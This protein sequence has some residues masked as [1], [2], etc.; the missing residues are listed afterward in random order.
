MAVRRRPVASASD[1]APATSTTKSSV[2]RSGVSRGWGSPS[3][4]GSSEA[5]RETVRSDYLKVSK[6]KK[7]I[8][9]VDD[10]PVVKFKR[11][12][13]GGRYQ[14]CPAS[15]GVL[16]DGLTCPLCDSEVA[17]SPAY[18][19][20]VLDISEGSNNDGSWPVKTY[21]F[22]KEVHD[23][24][25][26]FL[27]P[28]SDDEPSRYDPINQEKWYWHIF[29]VGGGNE[30]KSTK[31]LPLKARDVEEDYGIVPLS[32]EE[33]D[34]AAEHTYDEKSIFAPY[35]SALKKIADNL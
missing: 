15:L 17:A 3:S 27:E 29:Q 34:E 2:N 10:S 19:I 23:Q 1:E 12:Y 32:Q 7:I 11:H 30:R 31:V 25:I 35:V 20:N 33:L 14:N 21:T 9:F 24:L 18:M 28:E 6:E 16:E 22:G 13:V 26:S 5:K 8:H 4:G